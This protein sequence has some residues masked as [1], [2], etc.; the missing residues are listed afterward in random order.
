[1]E[2]STKLRMFL[3]KFYFAIGKV[4]NIQASLYFIC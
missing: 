4:K 1:M 3:V 2:Y